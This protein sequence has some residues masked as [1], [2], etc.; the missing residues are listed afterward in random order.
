MIIFI[1]AFVVIGVAALLM[2]SALTATASVEPEGGTRTA[3]AVVVSDQQASKGLAV[4]F[5]AASGGTF[6][7]HAILPPGATL[8]SDATCAARVQP[9]V[10][11]RPQ[12]AAENAHAGTNKGLTLSV[13]LARVSG[14]YTGTTDQII[15]WVACKWGID[16]DIVRAQAATES[17]WVQHNNY[18]DW[19]TDQNSCPPAHPLGADGKPGQ[20][21]E[22]YGMLQN[23]W[24]YLGPP[25]GLNTW[26]EVENSTAYGA[27]LAYSQWRECFE[28][29]KGWLNSV[30]HVGTYAAGDAW[31]CVGVWFSG[32][33]YTQP[34]VDYIN[35]VKNYYN[36]RVWE[37]TS[38]INYR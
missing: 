8:P 28:G 14:G 25:A 16:V 20:C 11:V 6:N 33:W 21:P 26:P 2:A 29:A 7:P 4:Q 10:E 18:G 36:T 35:Y 3:N 22:S 17:Y 15:Q 5:T 13:Y 27:D 9:A 24:N 12:N 1:A 23:R 32:R 19:T 38:F 34:A 31:G 37:T 30:D